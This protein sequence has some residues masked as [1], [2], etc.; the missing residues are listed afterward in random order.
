MIRGDWNILLL[1]HL[2]LRGKKCLHV[3]LF[4]TSLLFTI[5]AALQE[6]KAVEDHV[7]GQ[8]NVS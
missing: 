8:E 2:L 7:A 6:L 4:M 3:Q 1:F 5:L